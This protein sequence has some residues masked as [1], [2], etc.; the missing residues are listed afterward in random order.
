MNRIYIT[1]ILHLNN[2]TT[3]S[4]SSNISRRNFITGS[5]AALTTFGLLGSSAFG[6]T[7]NEPDSILYHGTFDDQGFYALPPLPYAYEALE[8]YIDATTMHLHHDLHFAA[9]MKG[10]NTALQNL[11][12]ARE[13]GNYSNISLLEND[14]AFH[15]AG[16]MLHS[17]FFKNMAPAGSTPISKSLTDILTQHFRSFDAFKAHFSAAASAVQGSGWAILGYQPIGNRLII[18]QAEKH[19]NFTQWNIIPI[20][21][22][23]VWEHAYYLKY[24]NKRKDYID[25]WWNVVNWQN[26]EERIQAAQALTATPKNNKIAMSNISS[27]NW[28]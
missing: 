22:L 17:I 1:V 26:V 16:Y 24:Q 5:A 9:Y 21:A 13:T 27:K 19:Q 23:D 2:M 20:L 8:P 25:A 12:Q 3:P 4:S 6:A 28:C 14:L 10:L 18:L 7:A 11:D 15:G